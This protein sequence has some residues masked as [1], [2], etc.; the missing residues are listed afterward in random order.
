[1]CSPAAARLAALVAVGGC[2]ASTPPAAPVPL[3]V[4]RLGAADSFGPGI[5]AVARRRVEFRTTRPAHVILLW[6]APNGFVEPV[7]P[8][9]AGDRDER[10]AGTHRINT[11]EVESPLDRNR[12][13]GAPVSGQPGRVAEGP[14]LA[15]RAA[16]GAVQGHWMLI[17]SDVATGVGELRAGLDRATP[18]WRAK[19]TV[20]EVLDAL[21]PTLVGGRAGVWAA[22]YVAAER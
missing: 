21:P 14:A 9:Y 2:A 19:A 13:A 10:P 8:L 17:V 22:Y 12:I 6:V 15:G 18:G 7:F 4:T 3:V 16:P 20:E 1:M 5:V 11:G